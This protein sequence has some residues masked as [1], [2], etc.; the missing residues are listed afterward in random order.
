MAIL[1]GYNWGRWQYNQGNLTLKYIDPEQAPEGAFH[2]YVNLDECG[3]SADILD[4]VVQIAEKEW[5]SPE[6]IGHLVL[7]LNE[8][9]GGLQGKVINQVS[10]IRLENPPQIAL[11]LYDLAIA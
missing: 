1:D 4:W 9:A 11:H 3:T 5:A 2:Y 7:A 8:L 6:D 10:T